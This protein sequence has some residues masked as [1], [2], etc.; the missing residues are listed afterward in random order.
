[1]LRI[2]KDCILGGESVHEG[3][4]LPLTDFSK[5]DL[6]IIIGAGYAEFYMEETEVDEQS[7]IAEEPEDFTVS[8][9]KPV[10]KTARKKA[11]KKTK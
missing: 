8:P 9:V 6:N 3:E 4:I 7:A 5:N 11:V 1:M 10:K 2:L